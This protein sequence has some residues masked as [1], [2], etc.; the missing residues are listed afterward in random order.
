MR[1]HSMHLDQDTLE[2]MMNGD[3]EFEDRIAAEDHLATCLACRE[4]FQD[5]EIAGLL[6]RLDEP[7]PDVSAHELIAR[8]EQRQ[9]PNHFRWAAG[10]LLMAVAAGAAYAAP[11]SPVQ[12]WIG[13]LTGT[14]DVPIPESPSEPRYVAGV[15]VPLGDR[16]EIELRPQGTGTIHVVLDEVPDVT[17]EAVNGPATFDSQAERL[18]VEGAQGPD[19]R[20]T[21]PGDA[22]LVEVLVGA[23]SVF[24]L[25]SGEI[26]TIARSVAAGRYQIAFS[27]VR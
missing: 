23:T 26:L 6:G 15:V 13:G 16:L 21:I 20:I 2:S 1:E 8:A 19:Y 11:G 22:V 4:L 5:R 10:V 14:V 9:M 17:V 18:V 12:R 7:A 24:R 3:L 27:D 25:E